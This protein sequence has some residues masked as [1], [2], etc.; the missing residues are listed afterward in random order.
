MIDK[1][2]FHYLKESGNCRKPGVIHPFLFTACGS[3]R[4]IKLLFAGQK[5]VATC[6]GKS[7]TGFL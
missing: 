4:I 2:T 6:D 5:F 3:M 1:V 7:F